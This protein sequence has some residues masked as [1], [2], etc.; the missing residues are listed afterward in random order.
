M[1][2]ALYVQKKLILS[3]P[4][5]PGGG[6]V[7]R[8]P[9]PGPILP[10]PLSLFCLCTATL[11]AILLISHFLSSWK[12]LSHIPDGGL[13][14][15]SKELNYFFLRIKIQLKSFIICYYLYNLFI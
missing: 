6:G 10:R 5:L 15:C 11:L 8:E 3:R 4:L 12:E 7:G 13:G 2:G 1:P 9:P 14:C